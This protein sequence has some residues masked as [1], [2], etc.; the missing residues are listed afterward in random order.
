MNKKSVLIT[1]A[2]SGLGLSLVKK[3]LENDYIVIAHSR[4]KKSFNTNSIK[5]KKNIINL[6]GDLTKKIT[7]HKLSQSYKKNKPSIII[8]NAGLYKSKSFSKIK[9]TE[10]SQLFEVNFF[11]ILKL[12]KN[13]FKYLKNRDC[14]I[15]N[16]NSLS[17]LTGSHNESIYSA[18]K[19]A[20]KG[21]FDSV[22]QEFL[23]NRINLIN[24]Y[25]GAMKTKITKKRNTF[26]K[27]MTTEEVSDVIFNM[28][29]NY[30]TLRFGQ[31]TL[32]RKKY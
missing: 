28:C 13:I 25:P 6:T 14:L 20:L 18:S 29:K 7:I 15:V 12:L 3:F 16:I 32:L 8:N 10:I 5:K 2:S 17:G 31:V 4:N 24:L 11:S 19:H 21:F 22:Q 26:N 27:L 30:K 1:G 9:M 23:S